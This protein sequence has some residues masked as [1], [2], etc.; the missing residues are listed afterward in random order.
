[1]G[2]HSSGNFSFHRKFP[3]NPELPPGVDGTGDIS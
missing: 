1:M 2:S 3:E